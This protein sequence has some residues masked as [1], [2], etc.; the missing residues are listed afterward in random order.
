MLAGGLD[1][2]GELRHLL[3]GNLALERR[4]LG[5]VLVV[6]LGQE[7]EEAIESARS[8]RIF[9]GEVLLP[10]RPLAHELAIDRVAIDEQ[11]GHREQERRLAARPRA[12]PH[13]G[14]GSGVRK[15][16]VD[17]TQLRAAFLCRLD[18]LGVRVEVVPRL[19]VRRQ[20]QHEL[21]LA[22]VG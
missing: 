10:V 15:S 4:E 18:A 16:R 8:V 7:L 12:D 11:L 19:E 17:G 1:L 21:R 20:E 2:V 5:C 13:V 6:L 22:V 14:L 3:D 9:G